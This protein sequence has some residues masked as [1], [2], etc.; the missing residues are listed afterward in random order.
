MAP[1]FREREIAVADLEHVDVIVAPEVHTVEQ[2]GVHVQH[3]CDAP[4]V[5]RDVD[6]HAPR[7]ARR[8]APRGDVCPAPFADAVE[9]GAVLGLQGVAHAAVAEGGVGGGPVVVW[10]RG[11]V[12]LFARAVGEVAEV[13]FWEARGVFVGP[14]GGR[15]AVVVFEIVDAP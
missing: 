12:G 3:L 10:G 11:A 4:P 6:R 15:P 14:V 9:D 1:R 5:G 2:E 7:V 13:G 8:V